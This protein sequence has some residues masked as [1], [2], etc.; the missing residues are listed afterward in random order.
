MRRTRIQLALLATTAILAACPVCR[1]KAEEPSLEYKV[2]AAC[3][4]NF[5]KFIEWPD[6]KTSDSSTPITIGILGEDNFGTAFNEITSRK[7]RDRNLVV[8]KIS[9][10]SAENAKPELLKCRLVFVSTSQRQHT[11]EV[12]EL[13]RNKPVLLVG[14]NDGFIEAGGIINFVMQD[15]KVCFEINADSAEEA[16]LKMASQLLRLA[17]RVIK[18]GKSQSSNAVGIMLQNMRGA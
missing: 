1:A 12:I 4:Y 5:I 7:I 16:Q 9:D 15:N 6:D 18:S 2:K 8:K 11:G 10:F 3:L 13:L 14:E 17:K